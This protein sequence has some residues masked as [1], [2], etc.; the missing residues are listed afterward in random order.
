VLD[1]I[2][3]PD[4]DHV[5]LVQTVPTELGARTRALDPKSGRIYLPTATYDTAHFGAGRFPTVPG[6]FVILIVAPQ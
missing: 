1:L 3:V 5:S 6:T 2:A 4:A